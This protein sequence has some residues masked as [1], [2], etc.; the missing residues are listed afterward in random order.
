MYVQSPI[1]KEGIHSSINMMTQTP[2]RPVE[3]TS[4]VQ[5]IH[6]NS[7]SMS[8]FRELLDGGGG[9]SLGLSIQKPSSPPPLP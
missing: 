7:P 2:I 1:L 9:A 6:L 8:S 3:S 4:G 5:W